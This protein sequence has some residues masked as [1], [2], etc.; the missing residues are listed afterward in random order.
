MGDC[1]MLCRTGC[2]QDPFATFQIVSSCKHV[3]MGSS[4]VEEF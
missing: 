2:G 4:G 3:H 1:G